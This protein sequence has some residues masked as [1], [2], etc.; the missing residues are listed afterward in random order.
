MT[1]LVAKDNSNRKMNARRKDSGSLVGPK[2]FPVDLP[3]F[4]LLSSTALVSTSGRH[5]VFGGYD[6]ARKS[7]SRR[8]RRTANR[9][10]FNP[11]L[12]AT[13]K[14]IALRHFYQQLY[15]SAPL[16]LAI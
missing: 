5:G 16:V 10:E 2:I 4:L 8:E 1:C 7:N 15:E 14:T 13:Q 6:D 11:G 9:V 3:G 12:N